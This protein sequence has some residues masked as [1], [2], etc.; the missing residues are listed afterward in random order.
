MVYRD[1][2][3]TGFG[4]MLWDIQYITV[5]LFFRT[6]PAVQVVQKTISVGDIQ[7]K[8]E[9]PVKPVEPEAPLNPVPPAKPS[10]IVTVE[11]ANT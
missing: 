2:A 8:S 9:S 11:R 3:Y 7:V 5:K 10:P 4:R 6:K 1:K